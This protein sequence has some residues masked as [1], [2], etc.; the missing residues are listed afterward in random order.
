M[1]VRDEAL[2]KRHVQENENENQWEHKFSLYRKEKAGTFEEWRY[3]ALNTEMQRG[4]LLA[5]TDF[6]DKLKRVNPSLLILGDPHGR[7]LRHVYGPGPAG[8][9]H[10]CSYGSGKIPEHS[11]LSY[12]EEELYDPEYLQRGY[13]GLDFKGGRTPNRKT[14]KVFHEEAVRG[15]RTVLVRLKQ[16]GLV[17]PWRVEAV[18][19]RPFYEDGPGYQNWM[20]WMWGKGEPAY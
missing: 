19:G 7:P 5:H 17:D 13:S 20:F 11:I 1:L 12:S 4:R 3:T 2:Q 18:F 9:R 14:V 8:I 6:E 15:W 10:C 16:Q